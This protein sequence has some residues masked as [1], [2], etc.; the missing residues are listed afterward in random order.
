MASAE[1]VEAFLKETY[2]VLRPGG[3]LFLIDFPG[4][5]Q[6]NLLFWALRRRLGVVTPGLRNFATIL[7]EE[8]S[9]VEPYLRQWG[10][11]SAA[12]SHGSFEVER[13]T[14]HVFLYYLVLRRP[15]AS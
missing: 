4:S 9:Y 11:V 15:A 3:R 14:R 8:W 10:R 1:G 5:P 7:D 2:R 6:I 13:W 12:L